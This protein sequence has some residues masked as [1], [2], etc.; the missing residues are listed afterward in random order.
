MGRVSLRRLVAV[1]VVPVCMA[2]LT[3]QDPPSVPAPTSRGLTK[4]LGQD[5]LSDHLQEFRDAMKED[6]VAK[7]FGLVEKGFFHSWKSKGISLWFNERNRLQTIFL[8]AEGAD[9]FR[10]YRGELPGGLRFADTRGDVEKKLGKP[11]E[12]GGEGVIAFW[13]DYKSKGILVA[14]V[15]KDVSDLKNGIHH[16][17]VY[18][19]QKER[20]ATP[21]KAGAKSPQK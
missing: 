6:P 21:D 10:Q 14:Y 15:S 16:I 12:V 11:E 3:A 8:Y 2:T 17:V 13:A 9:G 20:E 4:L 19:P 5:H 1:G 7:Y 18:A